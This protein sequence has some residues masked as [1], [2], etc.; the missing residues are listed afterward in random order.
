VRTGEQLW[1][2]DPDPAAKLFV[3]DSTDDY[4]QLTEAFTQTYLNPR[5][6]TRAPDWRRISGAK[7]FDAVHVTAHALDDDAAPFR[8]WAIESTLWLTW[9]LR[10]RGSVGSVQTDW[11]I[12]VG[13][14]L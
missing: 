14:H 5:N 12:G 8:S 7:L 9:S 1:L 11:T 13:P 3:I 10:V 2:F 6:P 4:Q